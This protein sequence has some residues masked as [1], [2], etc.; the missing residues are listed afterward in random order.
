M[1]EDYKKEIPIPDKEENALG[2]LFVD[3]KGAL[4]DKTK[5]NEHM[6]AYQN[7]KEFAMGVEKKLSIAETRIRAAESFADSESSFFEEKEEFS[8]RGIEQEIAKLKEERD[9]LKD[10]H[11]ELL[12][13]KSF[14]VNYK[15]S[16]VK[17]YSE[18]ITDKLYR[19]DKTLELI[20]DLERK[21]EE[22]KTK[23]IIGS[24]NQ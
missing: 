18:D 19:I 20:D 8:R 1:K 4:H 6:I 9:M 11:E 7:Q 3:A 12:E 2:D 16:F 22:E 5:E 23:V 14:L 24:K 15:E 13:E 10:L 21:F 17:E